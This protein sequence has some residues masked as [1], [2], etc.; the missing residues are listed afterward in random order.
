MI[1]AEADLS[2]AGQGHPDEKT[3]QSADAQDVEPAEIGDGGLGERAEKTGELGTEWNRAGHE[4]DG[5]SGR[6]KKDLGNGIEPQSIRKSLQH[7]FLRG[8]CFDISS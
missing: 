8:I 4:S 7:P 2:I 3:E 1:R 5:Q 6:D